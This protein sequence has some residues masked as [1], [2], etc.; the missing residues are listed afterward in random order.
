MGT[1]ERTAKAR[2]RAPRKDPVQEQIV[3]SK[4]SLN[5][6]MSKLIE[7]LKE[8]KR[9]WNGGPAP[10]IGLPEKIN[11]T[12]PL[13]GEVLSAGQASLQELASILEGVRQVGSM[14]DNY[15]AAKAEARAKRQ[16]EVRLAAIEG[17][18][19]EGSNPLTRMWARIIAPFS[20]ERGRWERIE[21]LKSLAR[22]NKNVKDIDEKVLGGESSILDALFLAKQLYMDAKSS[23]FKSLR[24]NLDT[25]LQASIDE[26]EKLKEKINEAK[27]LKEINIPL[28]QTSSSPVRVEPEQE[29]QTTPPVGTGGDPVE[30]SE[31]TPTDLPIEEPLKPEQKMP[32]PLPEAVPTPSPKPSK[33][34]R[35]KPT[36]SEYIEK[37]VHVLYEKA[38]S[39]TKK[40]SDIPDPWHSKVSHRWDSINTA[41]DS[42]WKSQNTHDLV[43]NYLVFIK[44]IGYLL[45]L[46]QTFESEKKQKQADPSF[47][48]GSTLDENELER[49]SR[50][51][52][53]SKQKELA[54]KVASDNADQI[55]VLGSE[56]SR[57]VKRM[58]TR[59][60]LN[61]DK[62]VRIQIDRD[63][64]LARQALQT[65]M[66]TLEKRDVNF[67]T[68][69]SQSDALY[70]SLI[71]VYDQL[72][73]LGDM[74][75]SKMRIEKS[76]KK[77][78]KER[79]LY[80]FI[81]ITDITAMRNIKFALEADQK[82]MKT[83]EDMES[84]ISSLHS[85][86]SELDMVASE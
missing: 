24:K 48:M 74:Y 16:Q 1:L 46:L 51:F 50:E 67:R 26:A 65:L 41:I 79:M 19:K 38:V 27:K 13:P 62:N 78:N 33:R 83:L 61:R 55:V 72:A 21:L 82:K 68:L 81:P 15:A 85:Q 49:A 86:M 64:R 28:E 8:F 31:D 36:Y 18:L 23:F 66:D 71:N 58:L 40:E 77:Q 73:D 76:E 9:G 10:K 37:A 14:Q 75:N 52:V 80:D 30:V 7:I 57:W 20:S 47:D 34:T 39:D 56:A 59:L 84:I 45:A 35:K 2:A 69:I 4:D 53:I 70:S 43:L 6:R 12:S 60:S 42:I 54:A 11:L 22:M 32:E 44:E 25:T 3:S 63:L 29:A 17:L 5:E